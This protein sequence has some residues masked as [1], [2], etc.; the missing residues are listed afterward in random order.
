MPLAAIAADFHQPLDVLGDLLAQIALDAALFLDDLADPLRLVLRE[1]R[2]FVTSGT[3]A[4]ARI[5]LERVRPMPW[6]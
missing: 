1:I 4:A 5:R 6:M 2:T 3:S